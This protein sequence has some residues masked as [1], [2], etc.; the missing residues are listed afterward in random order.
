MF[1]MIAPLCAERGI[2]GDEK[3]VRER[4]FDA[5]TGCCRL[6]IDRT[7]NLIAE[8]DGPAP[9]N[10]V[11]FF[12]HM[13]EVGLLV[14]H[15]TDQGLL[16]F[17]SI[18]MEGP[19][20]QGRKVF[21]GDCAI[22]GVIGAKVWHHVEEKERDAPIKTES[23]YIDIGAKDRNDAAALVSLGDCVVLEGPLRTLEN[24]KFSARALDN[25]IGCALLIRLMQADLPFCATGVFTCGEEASMFGA[26]AA[27]NALNPDIAV[28][29]ETTTAGDVPIAPEDKAVCRLGK[30]PVVSF[31]D[32][33]TLYDRDL[34][35]L[36]FE[37]A[38]A[39]KI[40]VQT[41]EGIYGGN[42]SRVVINAGHGARVLAVSVP[43]R[44]LHSASCVA[45]MQDVENTLAL[46]EKLFGVMCAL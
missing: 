2:S 29:L 35:R 23:L 15:I 33:G 37:T 39:Y 42:E 24:G 31:A 3:R 40:P 21:V 8:K 43:C 30:G 12:A 20:L 45:D 26:K 44:Y 6:R 25:R 32:K 34:Y 36:A 9:K 41:K 16:L 46:I 1:D 11:V 22:P 4:I 18:G 5:L 10:K 14:T 28:I 13:D 27:G 19:V 7:G 17:S 38:D